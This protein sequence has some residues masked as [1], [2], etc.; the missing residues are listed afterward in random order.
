MGSPPTIPQRPWIQIPQSWMSAE[1]RGPQYLQ[2]NLKCPSKHYSLARNVVRLAAALFRDVCDTPS[3][4][5]WHLVDI[6]DHVYVASDKV[7][8]RV[9]V[10][11]IQGLWSQKPFRVWAFGT[12]VLKYWVLGPSGYDDPQHHSWPS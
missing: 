7:S 10:P 12:R 9:R 5:G 2:P 3:S 8:Q 6:L 11:N 4:L 1:L